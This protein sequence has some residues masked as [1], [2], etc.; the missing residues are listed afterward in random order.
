MIYDTIKNSKPF[1]I[2]LLIT[3]VFSFI[4]PVNV[5]ACVRFINVVTNLEEA[6]FTING[7]MS[8]SGSGKEYSVTL[9]PGGT[10]TIV[11]GDVEGYITP[12]RLRAILYQQT[13]M[14]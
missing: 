11:F 8:Y 5:D 4:Y 1:V 3:V 6:T 14:L 2:L 9:G 12:P 13:I 10:Y 7:P